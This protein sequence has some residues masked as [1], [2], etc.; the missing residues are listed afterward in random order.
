MTNQSLTLEELESIS[1]KTGEN[2]YSL[3]LKGL[4]KTYDEFIDRL[5]EDLE[6][7]IERIEQNK[8]IRYND[9]EDRLTEEIIT[10][11]SSYGYDA[12]HD[13]HYGGGHCDIIVKLNNF[14]W[15]GE[16]KIHSSYEYLLKGFKQ[17]ITRYA[18]GTDLCSQGS[19][20]IYCKT[21]NAASVKDRW[22]EEV[23]SN[24][25]KDCICTESCRYRPSFSFY[26]VHKHESSGIDYKIKHIF[27]VL[28]Y[29]PKDIR[30]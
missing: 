2:I 7:T 3:L 28:H 17:L 19:L 18:I 8:K 21:K 16:A 9:E 20:I 25:G 4:C 11:L 30:N 26:T 5:Y 14:T 15:L 1:K 27:V 23:K 24:Y 13:T 6:M 22:K 29:D 10:S 12:M